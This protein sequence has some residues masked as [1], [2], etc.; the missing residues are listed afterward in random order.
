MVLLK[1]G[2]LYKTFDGIFLW[3]IL[4][5]STANVHS[6]F[7]WKH[8]SHTLTTWCVWDTT[9]N[10]I[11]T[12]CSITYKRRKSWQTCL[13]SVSFCPVHRS[14]IKGIHCSH[15]LPQTTWHNFILSNAAKKSQLTH[16]LLQNPFEIMAQSWWNYFYFS[17]QP[18]TG[19]SMVFYTF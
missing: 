5:K 4:C 18:C 6:L 19:L 1:W 8:F 15:Y 2:I 11:T 10:W 7:N 3:C 16:I 17:V 14:T 9:H 13:G 12:S